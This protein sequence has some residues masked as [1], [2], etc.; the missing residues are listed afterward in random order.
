VTLIDPQN[1]AL[2]TP[3]LHEVASGALDPSSIVVPIRQVL[4]RVQYLE[5]EATGIDLANRTVTISYG[6]DPRS[7]TV[8]FDQLLIAAGSRKRRTCARR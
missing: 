5:A 3:M 1:F 7:R 4:R 8:E 2:F 6:L